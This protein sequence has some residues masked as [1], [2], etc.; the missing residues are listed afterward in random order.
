MPSGSTAGV[1][2]EA[3]GTAANATRTAVA[4]VIQSRDVVRMGPE[5]DASGREGQ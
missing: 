5:C 1:F 2:A 3:V 4:A